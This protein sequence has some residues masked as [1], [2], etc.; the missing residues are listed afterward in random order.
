MRSKLSKAV[1]IGIAAAVLIMRGV[2]VV[3]ADDA[4]YKTLYEEQKKRNDDLEKRV[5]SLEGISTQ[6]LAVAKADIPQKSLDFFG[7]TE[8]SGFASASYLYDFNKTHGSQTVDG[9]T[10]DTHADQFAVNKFKLA[11]EKPIDYNPT[12]LDRWLSGGPDLR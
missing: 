11:L 9:R 6:N 8:I 1:W 12:E 10:F 2:P 4:D 3:H 5:S 7:Q